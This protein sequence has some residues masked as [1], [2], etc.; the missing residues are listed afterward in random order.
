MVGCPIWNERLRAAWR[1]F[2]TVWL[3]GV[4]RALVGRKSLVGVEVTRL[5]LPSMPVVSNLIRASLRRLLQEVKQACTIFR[6]F[7]LWDYA[8]RKALIEEDFD[9]ASLVPPENQEP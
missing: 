5:I 2:S 4:R 8:I 9:L 7:G 6:V 1:Q 3:T